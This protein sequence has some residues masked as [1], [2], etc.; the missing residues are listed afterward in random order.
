M[1]QEAAIIIIGLIVLFYIGRKIYRFV[2]QPKTNTS[3]CGCT[4]CALKEIKNDQNSQYS[5]KGCK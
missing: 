2:H 5:R 4:G 1:W 3:C